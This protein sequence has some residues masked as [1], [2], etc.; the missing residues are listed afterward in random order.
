MIEV[1]ESRD[2]GARMVLDAV[3][4]A[5]I[6]GLARDLGAG[7]VPALASL[8]AIRRRL[9]RACLDGAADP[10]ALVARPETLSLVEAGL[11]R[12]PDGP[13]DAE[14]GA[15]AV[16]R[17]AEPGGLL[18]ALLMRRPHDL[19]EIPDLAP[20]SPALRAVAG[21]ALLTAPALFETLGEGERHGER[22]ESIVA[23]F[24]RVVVGRPAD[25]H[26]AA[27]GLLFA[28]RANLLMAYFS[29]RNLRRA[30]RLRGEIL[31]TMLIGARRAPGHVFG[32]RR[33]GKLRAGILIQS[34]RPFTETYLAVS[35]FEA[36]DPAL[37]LTVYALDAAPGPLEDLARAK[38]DAY[39]VL[40]ADLEAQL[41]RLRADDLDA[42][43]IHSNVTAVVN[44]V[45]LLAAC[46]CARVQI[47]STVTPAT[48][49]FATGDAYLSGID[50]EPGADPQADYTEAL[51]RAPGIVNYYAYHH[52]RD[53]PTISV[54]RADLGLPEGVPVFFSGANFF[55]IGPELTALWARTLA[56]VPD[57]QLLI[58]PFA[59][60]WSASYFSAPFFDRL[61]AQF[62]AAGVGRDRWRAA[63]PVPCRADLHRIAALCDV[64][65]DAHPFSGACSLIDPLSVGLPVVTLAG[66]RF[67]GHVGAAM[68]AGAG[69]PDMVATD[70]ADYAA[71]AAALARDPGLR[72]AASARAR[73]AMAPRP[74]YFDVAAAGRKFG[75]AVR[76][77]TGAREARL[78][79][80]RARSPA[81][82]IATIE[83]VARAAAAAPMFRALTDNA[84]V[85]LL[86]APYLRDS[87]PEG[88]AL[89]VGACVGETA[90]PFLEMGWTVDLFE[91][92]PACAQAMA[93]LAARFPGRARHRASLVGETTGSAAFFRSDVGLS[94]R[95]PSAFGAT[96]DVATMPATRLDDF[97]RD[98][99]VARVDWLKADCEGFDFDALLSHDFARLPPRLAL[100][101]YS[102]AHARQ[103]EA[104]VA[105]TLAAMARHGYGAL[106]FGYEDAGNF[107]RRIWEYWCV[108]V[109]AGDLPK[110][111]AGH[112]QGNILFHRAGDREFLARAALA[113]AETLPGAERANALGEE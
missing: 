110:T 104:S 90:L 20:M 74:P 7:D 61:A 106:V 89:D 56:A 69:L 108:G 33:P 79:R 87:C 109:T 49:G 25:P 55:K 46:R 41:A 28:Q 35:Q 75:D 42:L 2:G 44:P 98:A 11:T 53:A 4:W 38:A 39:V 9:A 19:P 27:L 76:S 68:L 29:R 47:V 81:D 72:R 23:A 5:A 64:Y 58:M 92:D 12:F 34:L 84:I 54:A 16:A 48:S 113:L 100:V 111:A 36:K 40:G 85:K 70:E 99:G 8:R 101:E 95:A 45:A 112:S 96:K 10:E 18:A 51:H 93:H 13:D 83:R 86:A 17:M 78:E 97:A 67:R 31:E 88:H 65:L 52:D 82:L 71:K 1:W 103:G 63:R 62:A 3:E 105:A 102:T 94:G 6:Q 14:L 73:A 24:H 15:R 21:T 32:A 37:H 91:P 60:S 30:M 43:A 57:A 80:L 26:R 59:P 50:N 22:M 66:A 77:L 107:S